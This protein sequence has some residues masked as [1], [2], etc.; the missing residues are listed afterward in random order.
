MIIIKSKFVSLWFKRAVKMISVTNYSAKAFK[1]TISPSGSDDW[2]SRAA[3]DRYQGSLAPRTAI[4][5][6]SFC[7]KRGLQIESKSNEFYG[8]V[9]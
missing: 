4:V 3:P 1:S 5:C 2:P 6:K 9:H 8:D 7:W